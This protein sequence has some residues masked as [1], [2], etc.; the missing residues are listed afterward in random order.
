VKRWYG[1]D[2]MLWWGI[3]KSVSPVTCSAKVP[4]TQCGSL[5]TALS[6]SEIFWTFCNTNFLDFNK[7]MRSRVLSRDAV[8]MKGSML[9][10]ALVD[11]QL[12][13]LI[14]S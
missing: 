10:G 4:A 1:E 12:Q 3:C 11:N 7:S 14:C 5:F 9:M 13:T 6:N 8:F 2:G